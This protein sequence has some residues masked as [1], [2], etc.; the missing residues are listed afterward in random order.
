MNGEH[1]AHVSKRIPV[2]IKKL[3]IKIGQAIVFSIQIVLI[4]LSFWIRISFFLVIS[5]ATK[6]ELFCM[7]QTS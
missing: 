2:K 4:I 7:Q 6:F 1:L 5:R 3:W